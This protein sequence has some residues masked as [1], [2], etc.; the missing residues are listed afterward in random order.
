MGQPKTIIKHANYR[1]L[2]RPRC[3][4]CCV[5][6]RETEH[7]TV[8]LLLLAPG[9]WVPGAAGHQHPRLGLIEAR[10]DTVPDSWHRASREHRH[11]NTRPLTPR[12]RQRWRDWSDRRGAAHRRSQLLVPGLRVHWFRSLVDPELEYD[13]TGSIPALVAHCTA[14]RSNSTAEGLVVWYPRARA[15]AVADLEDGT[16]ARSLPALTGGSGLLLVNT[17]ADSATRRRRGLA[18][19]REAR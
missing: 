19:Y 17:V 16:G 15:A 13:T 12:E 6:A 4:C 2:R 11:K 1:I 7:G 8:L 5:G 18:S 10:G 9:V 3:Y 14:R